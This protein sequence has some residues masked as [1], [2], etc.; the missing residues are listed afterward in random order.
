MKKIFLMWSLCAFLLGSCSGNSASKGHD[1][2]HELEEQNTE[3][4]EEGAEKHSDEI[5]F[6]KVKADAAG[7]EVQVIKPSSFCQVIKT[8]GQVMP[9]QGDEATVVATAAGIVSFRTLLTEGAK[10]NKGASLLTISSKEI[11]DGDPINKA[12]SSYQIAK[13]EYDRSK[14]LLK[15][16][17]VSEREFNLVKENYENARLTFEAI[18][19]NHSANGQSVKSPISGFVNKIL[20]KEGDYVLVGQQIASVTQNKKL[21]LRAELSEKHYSSLKTITSANFKTPYDEKV[22]GLNELNGHLVSFGKASDATSFY[23]PVTFEFDNKGEV[24]PGAFVEVYLLSSLK[25]NVISVP[26][27]ALTEE[28]GLFFVYLQLDE[29]GYKKQ[30]VKLGADDGKKVEILS[31]IKPGDKVVTKGAYQVKLASASSA[32]PAHSH[33]H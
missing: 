30:E 1:H 28:G 29:E 22:Y 2:E 13:Q 7:V 12:R 20:V 33:E 4:K 5:I 8:S 23:I 9:A 6:P 31:G 26:R 21:F 17:I 27:T 18:S 15:S 16:R 32:I 11:V 19:K 14:E 24:V 3:H 10:V 25:N